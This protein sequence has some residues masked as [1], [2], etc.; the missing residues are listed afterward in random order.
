MNQEMKEG[1]QKGKCGL[2]GGE[3]K[4]WKL[5]EGKKRTTVRRSGLIQHNYGTGHTREL[6]SRHESLMS[7]DDEVKKKTD[8]YECG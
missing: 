6:D 5:R 4:S 3:E 8:S 7:G 1:V 2:R